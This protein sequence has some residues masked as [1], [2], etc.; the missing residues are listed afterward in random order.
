MPEVVL[1]VCFEAGVVGVVR[2]GDALATRPL[3]ACYRD[4]CVAI[5]EAFAYVDST[6]SLLFGIVKLT[7][8]LFGWR[9]SQLRAHLVPWT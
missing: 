4:V 5:L 8:A 3:L 7:L 9:C 1:E 6:V 2:A